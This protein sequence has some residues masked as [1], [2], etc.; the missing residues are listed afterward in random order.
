MIIHEFG[1]ALGCIH[2]HQ[3]PA[4]SICWNEQAVID[5]FRNTQGRDEPTIRFNVLEK[6]S[7]IG[8]NFSA[9][10][11]NSIKVYFFPP[12]LTCD[13]TGT[14]INR[15][16]SQMDKEFIQRMY[17]RADMTMTTTEVNV[18]SVH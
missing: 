10:D 18:S 5:Y 17:P 15:T 8:A 16:L 14:P 3:S 1:H 4:S 7:P 12:Q 13:G 6:E 2:E 11:R 9:F